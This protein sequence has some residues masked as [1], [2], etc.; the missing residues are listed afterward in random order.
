MKRFNRAGWMIWGLAI[1]LGGCSREAP[2]E[3]D[4]Y[5]ARQSMSGSGGAGVNN[6]ESI[7]A[8]RSSNAYPQSASRTFL[9][10][11]GRNGFG[12][13]YQG[14]IMNVP[15]GSTFHLKEGALTPPPGTPTGANVTLTMLVEKGAGRNELVFS[16]G[17]SGCRFNPPAELWLDWT[18]LGS[19][20]A[21]LYYITADG[22]YV[23][24]SPDY[25]D[26][27]GRRILLRIDHFSRYAVAYP[28]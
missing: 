12:C 23:E 16:F 13:A 25:V 14:G 26:F 11:Q 27:Q 5:E 19:P 21:K 24:Q 9:Y 22:K 1:Y 28:Q 2:F 20:H 3:A 17:P 7:S 6:L 8:G 18:D 15:N 4:K 10:Q